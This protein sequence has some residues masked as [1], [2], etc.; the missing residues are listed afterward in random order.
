VTRWGC[1][2]ECQWLT[3]KVSRS[4]TYVVDCGEGAVWSSYS[5]ACISETL[6]GLLLLCELLRGLIVIFGFAYW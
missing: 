1:S 6:K 5:P 3:S 2:S 4:W